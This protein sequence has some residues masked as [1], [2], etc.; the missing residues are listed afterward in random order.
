MN[1]FTYCGLCSSSIS[2]ANQ[3]TPKLWLLGDGIHNMMVVVV[4]KL[5]AALK[6]KGQL[7]S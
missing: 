7:I 3:P 2:V 6:R 4:V 5:D 1:D